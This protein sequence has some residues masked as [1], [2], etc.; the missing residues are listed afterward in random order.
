VSS[1]GMP[2]W[3]VVPAENTV[4]SYQRVAEYELI[5]ALPVMGN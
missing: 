1:S 2:T 5:R 3:F 4:R